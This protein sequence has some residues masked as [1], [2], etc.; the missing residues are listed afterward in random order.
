[1]KTMKDIDRKFTDFNCSKV[2]KYVELDNFFIDNGFEMKDDDKIKSFEKLYYN[3]NI[4]GYIH[5]Y[6]SEIQ[7]YDSVEVIHILIYSFI[8]GDRIEYSTQISID[9]RTPISDIGNAIIPLIDD[10]ADEF[11]EKIKNVKEGERKN[12]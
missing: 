12:D 7:S 1:M 5:L 10:A 2:F 11:I 3:K 8:N 4:T 9:M 6:A